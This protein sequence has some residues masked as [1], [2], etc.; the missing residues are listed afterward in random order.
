[1]MQFG[2]I[3]SRSAQRN[4]GVSIPFQ[5]GISFSAE[6][7]ARTGYISEAA[8]GSLDQLQ[9]LHVEW[10][11]I[12]PFAFSSGERGNTEIYFAHRG[13]WE[14]DD[15]LRKI[16]WEA[17]SRGLKVFLKPHLWMRDLST[18]D[19]K[20]SDPEA[21]HHWFAAY[22]RYIL[23]QARLGEEI[24]AAMFSVGNELTHLALDPAHESDWR[25]LIA[26]VRKLFSGDVIYCANWGDD[27]EKIRFADALDAVGLNAYYPLATRVD[28]S[29][30]E[31][32]MGA[33]AI[34]EKV[35]RVATQTQRPILIT[36]LGYPSTTQA[37]VTPWSEE[38]AA[39]VSLQA[40][41]QAA[42]MFFEVFWQKP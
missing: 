6:G 27:F 8:S 30:D 9:K 11:S 12:M 2:P 40:Q 16:A 17:Q 20:I 41:A 3:A 23:H 34:A 32:R 37:A 39:G 36:E 26:Q 35:E 13:T 31:W 21:W 15:S 28:A 14:S 22:Q 5:R 33:R 10:I 1:L 18:V 24:G 42:K 19:L 7:G 4:P 29:A 25:E 38:G